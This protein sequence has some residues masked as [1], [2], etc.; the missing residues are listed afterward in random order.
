MSSLWHWL[1]E[2][3]EVYA[4]HVSRH[5]PNRQLPA[6]VLPTHGRVPGHG[7]ASPQ[8]T[9]FDRGTAE[10]SAPKACTPRE[11]T[12]EERHTMAHNAQHGPSPNGHGAVDRDQ[13]RAEI[14][15]LETSLH[16]LQARWHHTPGPSEPGTPRHR[17]QQVID[18]LHR[19]LS[20]KRALDLC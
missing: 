11:S 12:S 5:G 18:L 7:G 9:G 4:R 19:E 2:L 8:G 13:L 17:I 15:H 14:D 16:Y 20:L 10:R 3:A 1:S 6:E